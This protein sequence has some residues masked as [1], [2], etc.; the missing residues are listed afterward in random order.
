MFNDAGNGGVEPRANR[1][2]KAL[3]STGHG[4]A[5]RRAASATS[6][7]EYTARPCRLLTRTGNSEKGS[8]HRKVWA[9]AW[10]TGFIPG[11][12]SVRL[13]WTEDFCWYNRDYRSRWWRK[14]REL[15]SA[16]R[17]SGVQRVMQRESP[18]SLRCKPR[19]RV[20][21]TTHVL[22]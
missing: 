19:C 14:Y 1:W 17:E 11:V 7:V 22:R 6:C 5:V 16:D 12:R 8:T 15:V 18:V 20:H 10:R 3:E 9:T 2:S 4:D 21:A 13:G